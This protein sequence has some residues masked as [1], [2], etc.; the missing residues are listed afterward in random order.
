MGNSHGD[1]LPLDAPICMSLGYL[2]DNPYNLGAQT[3]SWDSHN[4]F[5]L[6]CVELYFDGN[7]LVH[8]MLA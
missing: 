3:E 6:V 2:E 4:Q 7:Q 8:I 1:H 5:T